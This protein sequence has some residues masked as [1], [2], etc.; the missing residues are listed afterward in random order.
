MVVNKE[1]HKATEDINQPPSNLPPG[2]DIQ[3]ARQVTKRIN[4]PPFKDLDEPDETDQW[5]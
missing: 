4:L 3:Q 5:I 2:S 1:A